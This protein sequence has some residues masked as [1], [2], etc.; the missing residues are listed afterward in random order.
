MVRYTEALSREACPTCR[1]HLVFVFHVAGRMLSHDCFLE[2]RRSQYDYVTSRLVI[3]TQ[4][5][6]C[7]AVLRKSER[8]TAQTT[9]SFEQDEHAGTRHALVDRQKKTGHARLTDCR[10]HVTWLLRCGGFG[11]VGHHALE[12]SCSSGAEFAFSQ[13]RSSCLNAQLLVV[14]DALHFGRLRNAQKIRLG[15]QAPQPSMQKCQI[16]PHPI[17]GLFFL[18]SLLNFCDSRKQS[19]HKC[20]IVSVLV[21]ACV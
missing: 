9:L 2:S 10:V 12:L 21:F 7:C 3:R 5:N 20:S 16:A 19:A 18:A 6:P 11:N 17:T 13:L 15:K 8:S 14:W 1:V 4:L